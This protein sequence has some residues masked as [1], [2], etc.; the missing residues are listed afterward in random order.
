MLRLILSILLGFLLASE[1]PRLQAKELL[2]AGFARSEITPT[3]EDDAKPVWLA[4]YGWGRAATGVHDPLYVTAVALN[5]GEQRIALVTLDLIGLPLPTVELIRAELKE[6][7]YVMVSCT[8]NH[9]GPD[10][11]GIWGRSPFSRGVDDDYLSAVVSKTVECVKQALKSSFPVTVRFGS[12]KDDTLIGDSRLPKVKASTMRVLRFH[13]PDAPDK[14]AGTL[15]QWNC[16][17]EAL[18]SKNT[19]VTADFP[20]STIAQLAQKYDCPIAYFSGT[21]GGLMAPPRGV[22]HDENGVEL[23]EGQFEFAKRYGEQVADLAARALEKAS[24]IRLTPFQISAQRVALPVQNPLYRTASLLKLVHRQP[25]RWTGDFNV[26]DKRVTAFT[27]KDQF[28][29]ATEVACLSLGELKVA[30]IPGEI[31]PELVYGKI[32][33]PVDP[34]ADFPDA[35]KEPNIAD[36]MGKSRWMLF[37]LA[38]DEIGYIIPKRQWDQTSPFAYGRKRPQYGEVNSCGPDSGPIIMQAF[39]RRVE[40]LGVPQESFSDHSATGRKLTARA[41]GTSPGD[42][43]NRVP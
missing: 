10:T 4:G 39:K 9:E 19:L 31:Y 35:D 8:H 28:G 41:E 5:D 22:I 15:V 18:G 37:G 16:H 36:L 6:F 27:P 30:C 20:H 3:V 26:T 24:P 13:R 1:G 2:R 43:G 7:D 17:P 33:E 32:Q 40:A 34:G 11:I 21:L 42:G 25:V 38:N 23:K 14:V 29:I 12:A